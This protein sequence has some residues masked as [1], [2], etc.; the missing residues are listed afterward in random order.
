MKNWIHKL[1]IVVGGIVTAGAT[2]ATAAHDPHV[3]PLLPLVAAALPTGV[4]TAAVAAG[5]LCTALSAL[6]H[7]APN[8]PEPEKPYLGV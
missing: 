4:T 3:A 1:G 2:I 5:A 6:Y 8:Q 7:P